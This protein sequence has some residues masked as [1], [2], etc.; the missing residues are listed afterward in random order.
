[1][2][3]DDYLRK[4]VKR[5]ADE[6]DCG[7]GRIINFL[8][9]NDLEIP[10]ELVEKRKQESRLKKG[11]TPFNKGMKRTEYMSDGAI[12]KVRATQFKK[13]HSPHNTN[14]HGNGAISTRRDTKT[15]REYKYVRVEKGKWELYH[16][17]IWEEAH[18][19]IPDDCIVVFKDGDTNNTVLS[20]LELITRAENAYRN[21]RH[22][23]P[24][25]VIPSLLLTR[26]QSCP[27]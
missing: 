23:Y 15:G 2:I 20:N 16:R 6:L 24:K 1:M 22:H 3:K 13:A 7:Y 11:H 17:V 14:P 4:P 10:R 27:K 25:E 26:K 9:K 8:K 19:S 12:A 21:S 5:I 18:G